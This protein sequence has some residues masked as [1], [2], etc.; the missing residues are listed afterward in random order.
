QNNNRCRNESECRKIVEK[1]GRD[2]LVGTL[3]SP[4]RWWRCGAVGRRDSSYLLAL[5]VFGPP[6]PASRSFSRWLVVVC[7]GHRAVYNQELPLSLSSRDQ[8][9]DLRRSFCGCFGGSFGFGFGQC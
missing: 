8:F 1:V 2:K 9:D 7:C 3:L 5:A 6:T 4:V